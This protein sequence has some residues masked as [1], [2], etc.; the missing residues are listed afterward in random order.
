ML[1]KNQSHKLYAR[2]LPN[3]QLY[4]PTDHV[5][6][7]FSFPFRELDPRQEEGGKDTCLEGYNKL[8]S[9]DGLGPI[10][11]YPHRP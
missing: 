8:K 10:L 4:T 5:L 7:F 11:M 3:M 1:W 6:W 9:R 2:M